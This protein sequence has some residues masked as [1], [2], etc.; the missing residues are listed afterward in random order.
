LLGYS[1]P[2]VSALEIR[3]KPG[4]NESST[5]KQIS[6]VLGK[7]FDVKPRYEQ[8]K[9]FLKL[10]QV[11]KWLSY[12][13]VSLMML[14]V[15]FNIVGALWMVVLEKQRDIS[16]LKSMGAT[17]NSVRNIFLYEGLLL[18]VLGIFLGFVLAIGLYIA[19]KTI[20]IV[21]VPGN[22]IVDAYP[23]SMRVIDFAVVALTV[24]AIGLLA[25][26][27]P[28]QRARRVKAMVREE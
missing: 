19:Q 14:M 25:S 15:A 18:S 16:I 13:I 21:T 2:V 24:M 20:G 8:E 28:A 4:A 12:A 9:S 7:G 10:M 23:I 11:E 22:F 1:R 27:P 6:E 26:W 17:D 5:L 3:L